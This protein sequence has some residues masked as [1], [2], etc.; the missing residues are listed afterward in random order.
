MGFGIP[1]SISTEAGIGQHLS[2]TDFPICDYRCSEV[3]WVRWF[4]FVWIVQFTGSQES[5][6]NMEMDHPIISGLRASI[7]RSMRRSSSIRQSSSIR[8]PHRNRSTVLSAP[9][10]PP[11]PS[12][13]SHQPA[14]GVR[15][16]SVQSCTLMFVKR[17]SLR[18]LF[19]HSGQSD[20]LFLILLIWLISLPDFL[21]AGLIIWLIGIRFNQFAPPEK[22]GSNQ[23]HSLAS[24]FTMVY[25]E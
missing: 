21:G 18:P 3:R 22:V 17:E 9:N 10:S 23:T 5:I 7:R 4:E 1:S 6:V 13:P 25:H 11:T 14:G 15:S 24:Q 2:L 20:S 16:Q 12:T 8:F 19:N